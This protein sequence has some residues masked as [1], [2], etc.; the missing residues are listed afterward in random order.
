M[1]KIIFLLCLTLGVMAQAQIR[2]D[3]AFTADTLTN[4]ETITAMVGC[5]SANDTLFKK[6]STYAISLTLDELS[7]SATIIATLQQSVVGGKWTNVTV[8]DTLINA[9]T[10]NSATW[11][12]TG[13]STPAKSYRLSIAQT[14]TASTRFTGHTYIKKN[15]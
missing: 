10:P 4:S 14:G 5:T 7:G 2:C 12:F 15:E 9:G 6:N 3:R 8:S 1:R 11:I 13:E